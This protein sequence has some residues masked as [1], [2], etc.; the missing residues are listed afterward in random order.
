MTYHTIGKHFDFIVGPYDTA[1]WV[2]YF[3]VL[4]M[5]D[6][7]FCFAVSRKHRL[8]AKKELSVT[9]LYGEQLIMV[10]RGTS[11]LIDGIRDDL[12]RSHP[13]I[14]IEDAPSH[15]DIDVFNRCEQSESV[16]LTLDA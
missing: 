4:K 6:Y 8:A 10:K 11:A 3:N 12:M 13:Q 14:Q 15:Y 7:R 1:N 5:G 9:D 2:N 16:L